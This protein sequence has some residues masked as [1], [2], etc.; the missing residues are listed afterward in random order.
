M[1]AKRILNVAKPTA[2]TDAATKACVDNL[3][4]IITSLTSIVNK[5]LSARATNNTT[6]WN[7][8]R[9]ERLGTYDGSSN[10]VYMYFI[11]TTYI[12]GDSF[13]TIL[14]LSGVDYY[15]PR[16]MASSISVDP[17]FTFGVTPLGTWGTG[18]TVYFPG[19]SST[20]PVEWSQYLLDII[21]SAGFVRHRF[22]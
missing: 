19:L 4:T 18:Y 9:C 14:T 16:L 21:N 1:G 3:Q 13:P 20:D 6:F 17:S 15:M 12:V 8:L 22:S 2:S 10:D 5:L 7:S 11:P